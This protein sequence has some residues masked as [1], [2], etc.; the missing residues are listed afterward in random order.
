MISIV[1]AQ[2]II[3]ESINLKL[4]T[5]TIPLRDSYNRVLANSVSSDR[6]Y[7]P[8]NRSAM[9]GIA[10]QFKDFEKG[11][12]KFEILE[13]IFAGSKNQFSIKSGQ[14]YKIMTG[15]SVPDDADLVV[16]IEDIFIDSE[17][18]V[19]LNSDL[20]LFSSMISIKSS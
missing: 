8:F 10:I 1:E 19:S 14:C 9:D 11:I 3:L 7:P 17:N 5:E 16:K 12:S 15:A 4:G 6:D 2:K 20:K 18:F 13:T